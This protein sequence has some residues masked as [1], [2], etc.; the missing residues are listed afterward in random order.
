MP[1]PIVVPM[2]PELI[3]GGRAHAFP[4]RR[5]YGPRAY[6]RMSC[7]CLP[8]RRVYG[9]RAYI[10]RSCTCLPPSSCLWSPSLYSDVVHM[11]SPIVVPMVP[12]L[13]FGGRAHAFPHRRAYGPRAYIRRSCTCLPPSSCLWSPS[14]YSEVVHMP[15]PI[16]V[17]M[18][19]E[20]IFGGRAHAFPHRRV[21]GPRAYIRRPWSCTCLPPSSCLW[22]PSL[23][24]E[25]VVVHM[26]S[27]IVVS[28]VPELIF[29]G[30]GR[31]HAFPHRRVY[32]PRPYIRRPWSCT[33]FPHRRVYGPRAYIRRPWSC[34]CLPHRRVYGPRAYIRRSW[35]CTCLPPSSCLWSPTIYSEAVVVHMLLQSS[36]LWSPSLYSEAVVVHMPSP[37]SCLWSP[38]L[39]SEAVVV[40]MPSPI[41]V[42]MVPELI[43]GGRGRAHAFPHRRVYGPRPYIRRPWSCTCRPPSSCLWS[44]SLYSE[45]VVVH[46]PSP[47]V[48]SMVLELIFGD[49]GRAHAFPHR[50]VY[51]P[52]AYIRRPCTCLPPS[53]CL[54]SPS[55]YSE[56]VHMPSPIVVPMVPEL[57]FGG[58][59]HAFPHRRVYGPRAYIRRSCTCLPPSSC[60]WSPSLYSEVVHMP[61]PIVVPMVP[62]LIFGGRSHAFPHRRVYGPRA[63]IRRPW[64]CTCLPPSSCLWSPSLYSEVVHMPSPIV[65]PMVP[66]LIFGGRAHAFP[67][68]RVYGPRAYI[69]RP[70]SCTCLPPSSCLWSP[71]LYS[72]VVVVH[73][74]SPI[75]VSM[76]PELIF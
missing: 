8:H 40:H 1:S 39:Y 60:L 46:M 71:S 68:R 50:R 65:V 20:L 2:V 3:F 7:T 74:P 54:W 43:F 9:P 53:S 10:R 73:M 26:P 48:V 51:G 64:S 17:P 31:A 23:Y 16:V 29:G 45:V 28:M 76:V 6:I 5:S 42:S 15:S 55:L 58:R 52:R 63:C 38:S 30:R 61:S 21:Y 57:I 11:S 70:W 35:S 67:H 14:L 47:I 22:S 41:V 69:R 19:P 75:V 32:G 12:E 72:E 25:P 49:R 13:I 62:E 36:C 4:H 44:P 34:T 27:P 66:E 56:V 59:A 18:V 33:C 37:S 24:S